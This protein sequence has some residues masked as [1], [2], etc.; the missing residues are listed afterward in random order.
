MRVVIVM[1]INVV[2]KWD[3]ACN[4]NV[5]TCLRTVFW[6]KEI[7]VCN[8]SCYLCSFLFLA[9]FMVFYYHHRLGKVMEDLPDVAEAWLLHS[10]CCSS[11]TAELGVVSW[12]SSTGTRSSNFNGRACLRI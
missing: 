9:H 11:H 7:L 3:T 12:I 2:N 8:C 4:N 6:E 10:S 5:K 1:G